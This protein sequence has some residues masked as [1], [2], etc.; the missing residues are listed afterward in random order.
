MNKISPIMP[1]LS[2]NEKKVKEKKI[3]RLS[4]LHRL[5]LLHPKKGTEQGIPF[6]GQ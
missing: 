1:C 6:W 2:E 4:D 5:V 3:R